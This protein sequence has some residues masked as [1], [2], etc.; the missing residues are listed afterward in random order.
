MEEF[1]SFNFPLRE[2]FLCTS[3][4]NLLPRALFHGFGGGAR[5]KRPGDEVDSL[6]MPAAWFLACSRR[7]DSRELCEV[8]RSANQSPLLFIAFFTAH[9]SPLSERLEQATWS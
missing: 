4:A 1:F 6:R 9:R 7:S 8:K 5:E 3:P 2:Y